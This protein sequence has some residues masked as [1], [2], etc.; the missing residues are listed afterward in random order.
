M[1]QDKPG[2]SGPLGPLD[3][4]KILPFERQSCVRAPASRMTEARHFW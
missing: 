4:L 2:L 1:Q 3:W